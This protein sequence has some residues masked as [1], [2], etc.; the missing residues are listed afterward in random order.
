MTS[1]PLTGVRLG[2]LFSGIGGFELAWTSLGG[3]VAWMCESDPALRDLLRIRFPGVPIHPDVSTLDPTLVEPVDVVAGGS[4]CT[5]FS[6]AGDRAALDGPSGLVMEMIRV[7]DGL[8][9]RGLS[10]VIWENVPGVLTSTDRFGTPVWPQLL[11]AFLHGLDDQSGGPQDLADVAA[12]PAGTLGS[13]TGS[14]AWATVDCR[15]AGRQVAQNRRRVFL[16]VT[17][18]EDTLEG[19]AAVDWTGCSPGMSTAGWCSGGLRHQHWAVTDALEDHPRAPV[20]SARRCAGELARSQ[21]RGGS[22]PDALREAL[23]LGS[24]G[25]LR[26]PPTV[27][28]RAV[29]RMS[30]FGTF[31]T[32]DY[33][34][35]FLARDARGA[36]DLVVEQGGGAVSIRTY[37]ITE[38]ERLQGFPDG[39]TA[40]LSSVGARRHAIGNSVPPPTAREVLHQAVLGRAPDRR[41]EP[42][43]FSA[44]SPVEPTMTPADSVSGI[45]SR[46]RID[47]LTAFKQLRA[48]LE[49]T[50]PAPH[51]DATNHDSEPPDGR[52]E[53]LRHSKGDERQAPNGSLLILGDAME[54]LGALESGVARTVVTSPPY[55]GHRDYEVAGQIGHEESVDD[56]VARLVEVFEQLRRVLTDDGTVWLNVGDSY[57]SGN[58]RT[59]KADR[60]NPSRTIAFRPPTPEG[61]KP[62]DL[63]GVPWMLAF[64]LRD[65]GWYLRS[66]LV[67]D[68]PNGQPESVQDRPTRTHEFLFM[69][70][71]STRYHYDV[72]A[73][74][75]PNGRRTRSVW[76]IPTESRTGASNAA[77]PTR[78]AEMCI[79][80]GSEPGDFI[81]DP[82]LGSGTTANAAHRLGRRFIGI[83]INERMLG[84]IRQK[85][86]ELNRD[87]G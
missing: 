48:S 78:L 38:M 37:T 62:K 65:A 12:G 69:L 79:R 85:V 47:R 40:P 53:V 57:T 19:I 34:S 83:E 9:S 58:R 18:D 81:I 6:L 51:T 27:D 64:A 11:Y 86:G 1:L 43:S 31:K 23:E 7:V 54:A 41:A 60:R 46:R 68:K 8:R 22:L 72:D 13:D 3:T 42:L 55:W 49:P 87:P 82:F 80:L 10:T 32:S 24:R 15:Y 20:L 39:W 71:K 66:D 14:A 67:W 77:F 30:E 29:H 16:Q 76:N 56:Y 75:G 74:R 84:P 61:M 36:R 73:V 21:R 59:R 52:F 28:V 5:S 63:I 45:A 35:C 33:A 25:E 44:R 4:P 2:G 50:V 70:S 17:A 26:R